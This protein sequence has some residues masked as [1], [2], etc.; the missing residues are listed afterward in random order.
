MPQKVP[1]RRRAPNRIRIRPVR[2]GHIH[3]QI[4]SIDVQPMTQR[5]PHLPAIGLVH[6]GMRKLHIQIP[7]TPIPSSRLQPWSLIINHPTFIA[8]HASQFVLLHPIERIPEWIARRNVT[9]GVVIMPPV[10]MLLNPVF[11][12]G[13]YGLFN[14]RHGQLNRI[15]F[16]IAVLHA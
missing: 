16:G 11:L 7:P 4:I 10:A 5:R 2:F 1:S 9:G 12:V 3:R 14:C 15:G 13:T 8:C 6:A